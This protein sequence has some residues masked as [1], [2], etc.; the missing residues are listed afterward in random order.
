MLFSVHWNYRKMTADR[1][2]FEVA[3]RLSYDK[4]IN[5]TPETTTELVE[6][7]S[8]AV[9]ECAKKH[10]WLGEQRLALGFELVKTP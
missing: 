7:I 3:G 2:A 9:E 1:I 8:D 4:V 5:W 10:G 6:K